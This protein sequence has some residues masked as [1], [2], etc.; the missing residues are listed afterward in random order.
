LKGILT[1]PERLKCVRIIALKDYAD[2]L[3]ETLQELGAVHVEELKKIPEEDV[4]LLESRL[5]LV[6]EFEKVL[7]YVESNVGDVKLVE[8]RETVEAGEVSKAFLN[9]FSELQN[10]KSRLEAI[11]TNI[12]RVEAEISAYENEVKYLKILSDLYGNTSLTNLHYDGELIFSRLIKVKTPYLDRLLTSLPQLSI[13]GKVYVGD[14]VLAH[15]VGFRED[16]EKLNEIMKDIKGEVIELPKLEV[17]LQDFIN[18]LNDKL[19]NLHML[20]N[21]LLNSLK[22]VVDSNLNLIALSKVIYEL[23]R[24]RILVLLNAMMSNYG[25]VIEGWVPLSLFNTF[26][27]S[28]YSRFKYIYVEEG[29]YCKEPPSRLSNPR[30]IKPFELITKLYGIP[31]YNEWDPTPLITYSFLI[32]FGLMMADVVYGLI[33]LAIVKYLLDRVGFVENPFSEGYITLKRVLTVLAI[34]ATFFGFLTNTYAGYSIPHL[35]TLL[36]IA[37][38]IEF[39]K[40][41]LIIGLVHV[42]LAHVI[43]IRKALR[44][45]DRGTLMSELGL[46]I[47]EFTAL[48]YILYVFLNIQIIPIPVGYY[49]VF[50]YIALAG[51]IVLIVGKYLVMK[52]LGL[53][54]WLFDVTGLLGDVF[55]YTRIAGI[56]LA[57]YLMA[58]SF[59]EL[60]LSATH[61]LISALPIP[62]ANLVLGFTLGF[63]ILFLANALEIAFGVIGAFVHSLRL[64]FV[65]FLTKFY[66]GGGR[67][68][69]PFK[70]S[71]S[72]YVLIGVRGSRPK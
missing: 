58:K 6:E 48:P 26:I 9:L 1:L 51:L 10:I 20:R 12:N 47:S 16:L 72:Q 62:V 61:Y 31:R 65:E 15:V 7:T 50:A 35:P 33:L 21:D 32:F 5:R 52:S 66:E 39:I 11:I 60:A 71:I 53:F 28:I 29:G 57:T 17:G 49:V 45:G 43:A 59:N 37:S 3:V 14:D 46:V 25:V 38:P 63:L 22:V 42:N 34:S 41:S 36:D 64:C 44:D 30:P 68:F 24:E 40:I 56:G 55:S 23:Y 19:K 54:L 13:I 8:V 67:E 27:N 70:L 69:K 4:K 18:N 2:E